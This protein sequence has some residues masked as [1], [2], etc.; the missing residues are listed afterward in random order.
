MHPMNYEQKSQRRKST[1]AFP[2][3]GSNCSTI[4]KK[5]KI[6]QIV[7]NV[8]FTCIKYVNITGRERAVCLGRSFKSIF[9]AAE[10]QAFFIFFCRCTS[11]VFYIYGTLFFNEI[12]QSPRSLKKCLISAMLLEKE[13]SCIN[14]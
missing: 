11:E 6:N 12:G 3:F 4:R 1:S 8:I 13:K 5:I 7:I 9:Y 2:Y 10:S 14:P